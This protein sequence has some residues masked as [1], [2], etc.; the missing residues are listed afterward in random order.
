MLHARQDFLLGGSVNLELVGDQ[1]AGSVLQA[2]EWF[3][4]K[5][6]GCQ[7]ITPALH[8]DIDDIP[9]LIHRPPQVTEFPVQGQ[10]DLIEVPLVSASAD[11]EASSRRAGR[12]SGITAGSSRR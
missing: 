12:I 10:V 3:S 1:N 11:A 6:L 9:L 7:A 2:L 8:E 5:A 4:E